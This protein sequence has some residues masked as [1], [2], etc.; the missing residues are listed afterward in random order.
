MTGLMD[1]PIRCAVLTVSDRASRGVYE[2]K[3][4]PAIVAFAQGHLIADVVEAACLPDDKDEIAVQLERW[5]KQSPTI[6]LILTT[7]GTGLGP[8]DRTPEAAMRVI[9]RP[10]PGLLE[11][12][13]LRTGEI[14][15]LAY[16]SRGV[17]GAAGDTLIVT[18]PG[19]PKGA[20]EQIESIQAVLVHALKML[21]GQEH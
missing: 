18:L 7:G 21:R 10:H 9:D 11:L 5:V 4:G 20:V 17:A 2:D 1:P 8:R 16:L 3:S 15:E 14:T 19:S 6:D 12:A 13:R